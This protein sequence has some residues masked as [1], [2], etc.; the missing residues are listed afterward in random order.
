LFRKAGM[1]PKPSLARFVFVAGFLLFSGRLA[2]WLD[3]RIAW[4]D[5]TEATRRAAA[6]WKG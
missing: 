6:E 3:G 4:H 2:A 5:F 1:R